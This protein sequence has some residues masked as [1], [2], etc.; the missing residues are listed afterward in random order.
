MQPM[1]KSTKEKAP[2]QSESAIWVVVVI[3][4][5]VLVIALVSMSG[6]K[7]SGTSDSVDPYGRE[8]R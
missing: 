4:V 2:T 1:R 8:R 5:V 3:V 6:G 7:K